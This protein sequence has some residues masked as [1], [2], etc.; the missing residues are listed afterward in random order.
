MELLTKL[1]EWFYCFILGV[2]T[3]IHF[4]LDSN[5]EL[6]YEKTELTQ[7]MISFR[8]SYNKYTMGV[9]TIYQDST[10]PRFIERIL[11]L[12]WNCKI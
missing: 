9:W 4:R 8:L 5:R 10:Q 1:N 2:L 11:S 6:Q 7:E 12:S 3:T